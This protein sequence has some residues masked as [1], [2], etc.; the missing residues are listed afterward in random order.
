MPT[1]DEQANLRFWNDDADAYQ[2]AHGEQLRAAP[3]AWGPF[4]HPEH[5]LRLL[6]D[7]AGRAV[8]EYG[9]GA[10]QWSIALRA[11]GAHVVG[12]DISRAQLAHARRAD[13]GVALV[14]AAATETPFADAS[15]DIVFCDHGA[16]SFC[17]PAIALP[18]VARILRPGGR[19]V[20]AI[21][22]PLLW[23][24]YDERRDRQTDR[25]RNPGFG[26]RRW[27]VDGGTVDYCLLTGEWLRLFATHGFVA[28]DCV[29]LPVAP[30]ATTTYDDYIDTRLAQHWPFEQIW[31]ARRAPFTST[32]R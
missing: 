3:L 19:L 28:T 25:L 22:T 8:L 9:C 26:C 6:G 27:H 17:D 5:E 16:M 11:G 10:A 12:L 14:A 31:V 4:R 24:T 32:P 20:F 21:S 15:F 7:T 23:W 29:E 30:D 2:D 18:E 1:A 13:L